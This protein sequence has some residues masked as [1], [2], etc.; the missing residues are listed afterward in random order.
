M[1]S[2]SQS[3]GSSQE[4]AVVTSTRCIYVHRMADIALETEM[5]IVDAAKL[6]TDITKRQM[7]IT[8]G[9]GSTHHGEAFSFDYDLP[10]DTVYAETCASIGLVFFAH[11]MQKME[12]SGI[13]ADVIEKVLY[14]LVPGSISRQG[15]EFFYVN[16]LEVW[17]EQPKGSGKHHVKAERQKWFGCACCPP[18]IARLLASLGDYIYSVDKNTLYTHLYIAGEVHAELSGCDVTVMQQ[19][20]Y[21]NQGLI[22]FTVKTDKPADFRLALRI[23]EWCR[24][25]D[26]N[27]NGQNAEK[28]IRNGYLFIERT[29]NTGD[30]VSLNMEMP[31]EIIEANPKVRENAGKICLMR[32]P[33]VYCLEEADNGSNLSAIAIESDGGFKALADEAFPEGTVV[34]VGKASRITE[35][36]W[37]D[38]LYRPIGKSGETPVKIKAIP[39]YLWG[40]RSLGEMQVWCRRR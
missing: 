29:W 37:N 23:P 21:P 14:N 15:K 40:N 9:I 17:P 4:T 26:I 8:G 6:W 33:L 30:M 27:V 16:P 2:S 39:Y 24:E 7:Y 34:L 25:F 22:R 1:L 35:E 10:N 18:N 20:E 3:A 36:N 12:L 11:R 31:V 32:G 5:R 28:N 38:T 13:Y 19:S